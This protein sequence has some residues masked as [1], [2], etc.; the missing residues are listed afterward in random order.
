MKQQLTL[1]AL[2]FSGAVF[3]QNYQPIGV[4]GYNLDVVAEDTPAVSTTTGVLDENNYILYNADYGVATQSFSGLPNN[5][6][7]ISPSGDHTFQLASYVGDNAIVLS[8]GQTDSLEL[9]T[10]ASFAAISLLGF[11]TEG[12]GT[13]LLVLKFTD[14]SGTVVNGSLPDWFYNANAIV[15]GFDRAG[16]LTDAPDFQFNQPQMYAFDYNLTCD[17]QAKTLQRILIINTTASPTIRTSVFA[18]SGMGL[19]DAQVVET[20]PSCAGADNGSASVDVTGGAY[21][22]SFA[23]S[24]NPVQTT[25]TATDLAPGTYDVIIT[26]ASGCD[27]TLT[28]IVIG[29]NSVNTDVTLNGTTLTAAAAG[30][31]YQWLNCGQ[32]N[33]AIL[34]EMAQ[35]F[36]PSAT[37]NYSVEVTENGCIDTSDCMN[38][39][40]VSVKEWEQAFVNV[41]PNPVSDELT[42]EADAA[43]RSVAV[44]DLSGKVYNAALVQNKLMM[45]GL[46]NGTYIVRIYTE[47]GGMSVQRIIKK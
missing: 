18:V 27:D 25:S 7:I 12:D 46:A 17:D 14:G 43:I 4:T 26:D 15:G 20:M 9:D 5:G 24:T 36:T 38:V 2:V 31:Q 34:G 16:R 37:G 1:I 39:T 44:T 41:S 35:T 30:A 19:L 33:V 22:V 45:G 28:G 32:N 23:W 40:V 42:I 10:P 13:I 21:P 8:T 11:A 3:A 29:E 6:T 47:D